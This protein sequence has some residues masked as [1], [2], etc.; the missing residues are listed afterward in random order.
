M[1]KHILYILP[2]KIV[3]F[4]ETTRPTDV[5]TSKINWSNGSRQGVSSAATREGKHATARLQM[6][7]M[8]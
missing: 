8:I 6:R 2:H 7:Q 1:Y 5:V 4:C 3:V